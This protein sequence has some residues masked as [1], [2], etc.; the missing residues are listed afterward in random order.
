MQNPKQV[1]NILRSVADMI[2][3]AGY[4]KDPFIVQGH[5]QAPL[6]FFLALWLPKSQERDTTVLVPKDAARR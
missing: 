3:L 5:P 4:P 2:D 1:A 6:G